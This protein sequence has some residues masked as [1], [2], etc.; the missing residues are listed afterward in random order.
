M[1]R[2]IYIILKDYESKS[3]LKKKKRQEKKEKNINS[4]FLFSLGFKK[5][6]YKLT[7]F[8]FSIK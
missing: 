1:K 4:V 5:S 8:L 6:K 7:T 3:S 2:D